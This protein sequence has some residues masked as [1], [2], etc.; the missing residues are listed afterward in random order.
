MEAYRFETVIR[1]NGIIQIPEIARLA[2]Q[3]VEILVM[4]SP[5]DTQETQPVQS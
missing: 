2:H 5:A 4:V 1:E 3:R